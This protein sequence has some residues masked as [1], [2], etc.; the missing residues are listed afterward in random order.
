M[1][2]VLVR[3]GHAVRTKQYTRTR[4]QNTQCS[5]SRYIDENDIVQ[6]LGETF[7]IFSRL[8]TQ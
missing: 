6:L 1:N 8:A 3:Y 4:T 2:T 5:E 7:G